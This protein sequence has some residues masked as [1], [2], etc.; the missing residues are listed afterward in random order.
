MHLRYAFLNEKA[1]IPNIL[2]SEC[3]VEFG[4]LFETLYIVFVVDIIC[5][6]NFLISKNEYGV[7]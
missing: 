4:V 1:F 6:S 2:Y 3:V 5:L 7:A